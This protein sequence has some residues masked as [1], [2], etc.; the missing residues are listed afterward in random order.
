MAIQYQMVG[1]T[2]HRSAMRRYVRSSLKF[3]N[4][5]ELKQTT[6][7]RQQER[8]YTKGLINLNSAKQQREMTK[9]C[10]FCRT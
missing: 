3:K 9:L 8:H 1:L 6:R 4:V 7:Q 10:V 2:V 5:T